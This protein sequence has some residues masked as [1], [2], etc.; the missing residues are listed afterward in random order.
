MTQLKF[1]SLH[2]HTVDTDGHQS[3]LEVLETAEKNGIGVIAFTDHDVLPQ[4][5]TL[6]QL[7]AYK[8]P[9]KWFIGCELSSKL[10]KELGSPKVI[11]ILGL[12]TDPTD[13]G[14]LKHSQNLV[15]SRI[16]RMKFMV[17]HLN[18]VGFQVTA[19]D[20]VEVSGGRTIGSPQI[21]K[22]VEKY[23]ANRRLMQKLRN[24]METEAASSTEAAR[25]YDQLQADGE[26][27]LPYI[28]F[29]RSSSYIPMPK[30]DF[31]GL[32]DFDEGVKLIRQA[33]GVALFAHW[34]FH[35]RDIPA[36]ALEKVLAEKRLDG[37]ETDVVNLINN[38]PVA[39]DS[40]L[41]R[42][43]AERQDVLQSIGAD[44]HDADDLAFF[45]SSEAAQR[46]AGQT[47][48]IIKKINP[49]LQWSNLA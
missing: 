34:F 8:G 48:R 12:F 37:V 47:A 42:Q 43:M 5:E 11:H 18:S 40:E 45:A 28:L 6:E 30:D 39:A 7:K 4:P 2:N 33:G 10:P 14:L 15:D 41:L 46:S 16:R 44:G 23:P 32:V 3:H 19:E 38:R 36:E 24:R 31:G 27:S 1:E 29:M 26:R 20:C 25:L 22:A 49:D 21:V 13:P 9:V 35:K 17:R